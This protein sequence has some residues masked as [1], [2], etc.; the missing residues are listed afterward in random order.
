MTGIKG[1]R[2]LG[3]TV[4]FWMLLPLVWILGLDRASCLFGA[5][6]RCIAPMLGIDQTLRER[7]ALAMPEKSK[8]EIDAIVSGMWEHLSRLFAELVFLPQ[9]ARR[10]RKRI[11]LQGEDI[12][13]RALSSGRG[14]F[15]L[16]G[17]LGNW[18][19]ALPV[20]SRFMTDDCGVFGVYRPL[21]N[22]FLEKRLLRLR[23]RAIQHAMP[24]SLRTTVPERM[25][26]KTGEQRK[27]IRAIL[28]VLRER[29]GITM[30]VDQKT[31]QGIEARFF[32]L[33]AMTTHLPAQLAIKGGHI[34]LPFSIER[35]EGVHFTFRFHEPIPTPQPPAGTAAVLALTQQINDFL[36]ERIR[37]C[38]EQWLWL[39][40]RWFPN[41]KKG[42]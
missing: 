16:S 34:L 41:V 30:L 8:T 9:F 19:L 29:H 12:L 17:H 6:G 38:P 21:N 7:V 36:E 24:D 20:L 33:P 35:T 28:R 14:V 40:N 39:H 2:Y 15:L 3:E 10:Y 26:P 27:N 23:L 31:N 4:L 18:E 5:V 13:R 11:N 1:L 25:I 37:A 42:R 22:P 32:S